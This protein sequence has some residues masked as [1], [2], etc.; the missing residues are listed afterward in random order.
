MPLRTHRVIVHTIFRMEKAE[1][2]LDGRQFLPILCV[3]THLYTACIR[4]EHML[5]SEIEI[6]EEN[7]KERQAPTI[8]KKGKKQS[9]RQTTAHTHAHR[10]NCYAI[11]NKTQYSIIFL[12]RARRIQHHF[13]YC[14]CSWLLS[15]FISF[16]HIASRNRACTEKVS[17]KPNAY[18]LILFMCDDDRQRHR[19][20]R[21]KRLCSV[22]FNDDG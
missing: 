2:V 1:L 13:F 7:D 22:D 11:A 3:C 14:M 19:R 12:C 5:F 4:S 15:Y 20:C 6:D 18:V 17:V 16:S 8:C 21:R 10:S 9:I